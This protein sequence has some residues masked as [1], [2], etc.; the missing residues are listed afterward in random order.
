MLREMCLYSPCFFLCNLSHHLWSAD[1]TLV[2][3]KSCS[4]CQRHRAVRHLGCW[5]SLAS[6]VPASHSKM[7]AATGRACCCTNVEATTV[8]ELSPATFSSTVPLK[9]SGKEEPEVGV[10]VAFETPEGKLVTV[11]L[12]Q[13]PWGT[14]HNTTAQVTPH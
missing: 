1:T 6:S 12:S 13:R 14:P 7:G 8:Q 11:V 3:R 9:D 2:I 5:Q 10:R 4:F